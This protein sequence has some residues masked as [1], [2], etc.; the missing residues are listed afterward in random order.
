M[1]KVELQSGDELRG[2]STYGSINLF[3]KGANLGVIAS[4]MKMTQ[5]LEGFWSFAGRLAH[6]FG[7][8]RTF[9]KKDPWILQIE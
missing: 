5:S 3:R 9:P 2:N 8:F 6:N 4:G 7:N 1:A